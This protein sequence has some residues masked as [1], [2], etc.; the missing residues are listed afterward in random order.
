MLRVSNDPHLVCRALVVPVDIVVQNNVMLNNES[1]ANF[2]LSHQ[3][4]F[5]GLNCATCDLM[6]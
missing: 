5:E 1:W 6:S 2:E 3:E 4:F